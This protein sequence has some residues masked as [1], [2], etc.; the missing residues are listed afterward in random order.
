VKPILAR[1]APLGLGLLLGACA[2]GEIRGDAPRIEWS[3]P[4]HAIEVP[5][6]AEGEKL[7]SFTPIV[8]GLPGGT[9]IYVSDPADIDI[10]HRGIFFVSEE[11]SGDPY[12]VIESIAEIDQAD[13]ENEAANCSDPG[14]CIGTWSIV[15]IRVN[16]QALLIEK[17][18]RTTGIIW[19]EEGLHMQVQGPPGTFTATDAIAVANDL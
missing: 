10:D 1:L 13:L 18:D 2:P 15:N 3:Q 16:H 9:R 4:D 11:A 5:D 7:L 14:R 6:V 12:W 17:G 19:I 8:S